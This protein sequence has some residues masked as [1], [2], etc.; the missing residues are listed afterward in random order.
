MLT[1]YGIHA[2]LFI[3]TGMGYVIGNN[4]LIQKR[5]R[6]SIGLQYANETLALLSSLGGFGGWFCIIPASIMVANSYEQEFQSGIYFALA[7]LLG[8]FLAGLPLIGFTLR[9]LLSPLTFPVNV[10]LVY[11]TYIFYLK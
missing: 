8:A 1:T 9:Q 6:N 11:L 3:A 10:G 4:Q 5:V 7:T 2:Y